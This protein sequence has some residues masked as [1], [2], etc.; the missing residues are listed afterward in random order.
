MEAY[1]ANFEDFLYMES[2]Y[3]GYSQY[4]TILKALHGMSK[5]HK[6]AEERFW[7]VLR[8]KRRS[9]VKLIAE[10]TDR[11]NDHLW[12]LERKDVT[13]GKSR[14]HLAMMM[15]TEIRI[16]D[17]ELHEMLVGLKNWT[18]IFIWHSKISKLQIVE[19][20]SLGYASYVEL[21]SILKS[22]FFWRAQMILRGSILILVS[23][24]CLNYL[25]DI[26]ISIF[27][28]VMMDGDP[29]RFISANSNDTIKSV[30]YQI[31]EVFG[32][33]LTL[34]KIYYF[35]KRLEWC[36]TL[37][38]CSI[39]NYACLQ[40]VLRKDGVTRQNSSEALNLVSQIHAM[41]QRKSVAFDYG[42]ISNKIRDLFS[43]LRQLTMFL[44]VTLPWSFV[45]FM[46]IS[47]RLVMR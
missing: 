14:M 26:Y 41:C 43:I 7:N 6:S 29:S 22:P 1:L 18:L 15:M 2:V 8:N 40:V 38:E 39:K 45:T 42:C 24:H 44:L 9:L 34:Q 19:Y 25:T 12:L 17:V 32:I 37:K 30:H 5:F 23:F 31:R 4:L 46:K 20:N 35:G 28:V 21:Y 33:P 3:C 13:D 47:K 16:H 10:G 11:S 27:V 36:Q